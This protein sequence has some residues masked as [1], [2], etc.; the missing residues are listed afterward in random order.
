MYV[1]Y[2]LVKAI[3]NIELILLLNRYVVIEEGILEAK[4]DCYE[5]DK[6]KSPLFFLFFSTTTSISFT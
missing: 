2:D 6:V 4:T 3:I 1:I 5:K